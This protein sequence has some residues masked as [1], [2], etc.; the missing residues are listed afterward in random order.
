MKP[1]TS[2]LTIFGHDDIISQDVEVQYEYELRG[3]FWEESWIAITFCKVVDPIV[4]EPSDLLTDIIEGIRFQE[5]W[6]FNT[7]IVMECKIE[8][9]ITAEETVKQ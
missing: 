5:G 1:I 7:T 4:I 3:G 9:V 2:T 6:G 8:A